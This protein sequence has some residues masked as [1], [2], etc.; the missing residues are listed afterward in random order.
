MTPHDKMKKNEF[1]YTFANS[2]RFTCKIWALA[3]DW[4]N[5]LIN[6]PDHRNKSKFSME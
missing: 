4:E 5:L 1:E 3:N 2:S 6:D